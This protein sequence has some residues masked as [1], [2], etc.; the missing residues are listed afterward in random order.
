MK[1]KQ[2]K[3]NSN[4]KHPI[5]ISNSIVAPSSSFVSSDEDDDDELL[6]YVAFQKSKKKKVY[7]VDAILTS[8]KSKSTSE[9]NSS[10]KSS[11]GLDC[12]SSITTVNKGKV[13]AVSAVGGEKGKGDGGLLNLEHGSERDA[14]QFIEKKAQ[15]KAK[16][17]FIPDE[18]KSPTLLQWHRKTIKGKKKYTGSSSTRKRR[19]TSTFQNQNPNNNN[20]NE[21][22]N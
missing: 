4:N 14:A 21:Y 10:S 13:A 15:Q 3:P 16:V 7:D 18:I 19:R 17:A 11:S 1:T 6:N 12:A 5:S 9:S 8:W 20:N 22:S 2:T